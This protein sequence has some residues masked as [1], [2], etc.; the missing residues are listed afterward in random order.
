M[1]GDE[2]L[3][4]LFSLPEINVGETQNNIRLDKIEAFLSK[5]I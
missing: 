4:N 3:N 1:V 2:N 5:Y